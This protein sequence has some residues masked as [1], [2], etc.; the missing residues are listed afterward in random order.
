MNYLRYMQFD[1]VF[2]DRTFCR[3]QF[4]K[5]KKEQEGKVHV[6]GAKR[7]TL[8]IAIISFYFSQPIVDD[9]T[10]IKMKYI[11]I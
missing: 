8:G 5:V 10:M 11:L 7:I 6:F 3:A 2:K 9:K 1:Y 4:I